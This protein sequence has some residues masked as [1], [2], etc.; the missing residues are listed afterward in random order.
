MQLY[1][2][3]LQVFTFVQYRIGIQCTCIRKEMFPAT[4]K[5]IIK[6][7]VQITSNLTLARTQ[8]ARVERV[9]ARGQCGTREY[10]TSARVREHEYRTSA[11]ARVRVGV[12]TH[13]RPIRTRMVL[14]LT[15]LARARATRNSRVCTS[16]CSTSARRQC[17]RARE[18]STRTREDFASTRE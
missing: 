9:L 5:I 7:T 10:S 6:P 11:R 3:I 13:A 16:E 14:P 8:L 1:L 15:M 4:S 18:Y 12:C 17:T 2:H